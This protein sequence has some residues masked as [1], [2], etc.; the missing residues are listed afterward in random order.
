M[1]FA[2]KNRFRK[3]PNGFYLNNMEDGNQFVYNDK[4][5]NELQNSFKRKLLPGTDNQELIVPY[6][7]T[8]SGTPFDILYNSN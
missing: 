4:I 1:T 3:D 8:G 5:T 2:F 7:D 6:A